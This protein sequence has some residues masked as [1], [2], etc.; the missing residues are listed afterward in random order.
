M[1]IFIHFSIHKHVHAHT[2]THLYGSH[3]IHTVLT[4]DTVQ[5]RRLK[6]PGIRTV[7]DA[8]IVPFT[9]HRLLVQNTMFP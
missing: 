9:V 7:V 8:N 6:I 4:S 3:F 5:R 1:E 2:C